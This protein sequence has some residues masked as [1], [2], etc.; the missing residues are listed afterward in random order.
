MSFAVLGLGILAGCSS[1][2][3]AEP[4]STSSSQAGASA[5]DVAFAQSMIP[6][7]QQAVEMA[8]LALSADSGASEQVQQLAQ[9]I[10]AAQDPE[11]EQMTGWLQSWNAPTAMPGASQGTD[12]QGMDHSGHDMGGITMAGMMTAE[13]MDELQQASGEQFDEMWLTMMIAHHEGA[14][15]MAEQVRSSSDPNVSALADNIISSQQAEI[16]QMKAMLSS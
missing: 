6:H 14:V 12:M 11:I 7:H 5:T 15:A 9:Q 4:V 2:E 10:K 8:D 1:S 3:S 13:Q 16:Q